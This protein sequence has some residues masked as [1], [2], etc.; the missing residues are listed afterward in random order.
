M[1]KTPLYFLAFSAVVLLPFAAHAATTD[2]FG[3]IIN[4]TQCLC[5]GAAPGWG[6]VLESIRVVLNFGISI[7]CAIATLFIAYA[8]LLFLGSSAN[9]EMRSK[10]RTVLLNVIIGLLISLS[11]WLIVD[12]VMSKLYNP[13]SVGLP[14]YSLLQQGS[15]GDCIS[16]QTTQSLFSGSNVTAVPGSTSTGNPAAVTG[17]PG[18]AGSSHLN[19]AAA[20]AAADSNAVG[21]H[22]NEGCLHAVKLDLAAGGVQ[23]SCP[24]AGRE[25]ADMCGPVLQQHGFNAI[26]SDD[27]SPQAG[28]VVVIQPYSGEPGIGG[29][30]GHIAIYDGHAWKSD[31]NQ[32]DF[33]GGSGYR[34]HQPSHTFYRP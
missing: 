2:F 22:G 14:W 33:W 20:V 13:T 28:D 19:I 5:P 11:A 6:C 3:P 15:A 9:P 31:F 4:Q 23:I 24:P 34:T 12:F 7:A 32:I 29:L 21:L 8:G 16:A 27:P 25:W 30:A 18:V 10:A 1:R 17:Q 26:G